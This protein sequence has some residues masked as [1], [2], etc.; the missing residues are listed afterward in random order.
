MLQN[1]PLRQGEFLRSAGST[2]NRNVSFRFPAFVYDPYNIGTF[3]IQSFS[4]FSYKTVTL[5]ICFYNGN[6][7]LHYE[8]PRLIYHLFMIYSKIPKLFPLCAHALFAARM[9]LHQS[10]KMFQP[11]RTRT[12][13]LDNSLP[14]CFRPL[15]IFYITPAV[16]NLNILAT[17]LSLPCYA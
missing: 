1:S 3:F 9:T 5:F 10:N 2:I 4:T 16:R 8:K 14:N 6:A 11:K 17:S 13:S 7:R 12:I 15:L